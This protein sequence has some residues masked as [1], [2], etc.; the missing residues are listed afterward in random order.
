MPR[1]VLL[2]LMAV[3]AL[4]VA[5]F[6]GVQLGSAQKSVAAMAVDAPTEAVPAI[7]PA[8]AV[9][10]IEAMAEP[11]AAM[12]AA[13]P[14][15][16][17][18]KLAGE[19]IR[20]GA[21][22]GKRIALTFDDGPHPALTPQFVAL[23]REEEVPA[24]FFMLGSMVEKNRAIA[25]MVAEAGFEVGGHSYNHPDLR[26]MSAA[27]VLRELNETSAMIEEA[28]GRRPS[29]LRPPYGSS[30]A[31][32]REVSR[33]LGLVLTNWSV[34]PE[35]WRARDSAS[36]HKKVLATAHPGGIVCLHDTKSR[37]L[38]ALPAII[39]DLREQGYE[40]V[41]V[42][43]LLTELVAFQTAAAENGGV[44]VTGD[45]APVAPPA[46]LSF[47]DIRRGL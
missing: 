36:I 42:G 4:G 32:V 25:R 19:T 5:F 14:D 43:E 41:T 17:I 7:E 23:L 3:A 11:V 18:A 10:L 47:E 24:T 30:N 44:G 22:V 6:V 34:D 31:T 39:R 26:K 46:A 37:T 33:E 38:E 35:D 28:T 40:F 15:E 12:A 9:E 1:L 45:Q 27:E 2:L 16:V 8:A 21:G 20:S 29:L 13:P